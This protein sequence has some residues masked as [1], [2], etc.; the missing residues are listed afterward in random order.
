MRTKQWVWIVILFI[1]KL[2]WLGCSP[3]AEE[4]DKTVNLIPPDSMPIEMLKA[5]LTAR[6]TVRFPGDTTTKKKGMINPHLKSYGTEALIGM[7][8]NREKGIYGEDNRLDFYQV[9]QKDLLKSGE[10]V[11]ALIYTYAIRDKGN[12]TSEILSTKFQEAHNLCA[13]EPFINQP[14]AAFCSGFGIFGKVIATAGHCVKTPSDLST[15]RVVFGYRMKDSS[16]PNLI[17]SNSNIYK[18]TRIIAHKLDGTTQEDYCLFEVDRPLPPNRITKVNRT[19]PVA[20]GD[21]VYVVGHPCGLP[22][23]FA[24]GASIRDIS[25]AYYFVANLDTYGGNSGSPVF[26]K[27]SHQ[28]V[29]ILVRG[30]TDFVTSGNCTISYVCPNTGCKG[31]DISRVSQFAQY[32]P[33]R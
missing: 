33:P 12:G 11:C 19:N 31:E 28:V 7:I 27:K 25:N 21:S 23:K 3:S 18:P 22:Q 9:K 30:E 1:F 8:I 17:I 2:T 4:T 15:F 29:G 13:N 5:E 10:A 6:D 26:N 14:V 24:A 32:I 20:K 16:T